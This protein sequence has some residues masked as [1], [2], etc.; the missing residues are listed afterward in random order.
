MKGDVGRPLAVLLVT[1]LGGA[2]LHAQSARE[3]FPHTTDRGRAAVEYEDDDLQVVAA[4]YYS[5]RHHESRWLLIEI[6]VSSAVPMR[7]RPASAGERHPRNDVGVA[8]P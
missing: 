2:P 7:I 8:T 3:L 1:L 5:Q 4:Y 6:A